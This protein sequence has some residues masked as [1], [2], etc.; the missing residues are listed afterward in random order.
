MNNTLSE[1][2]LQRSLHIRGVLS[3]L[4]MDASFEDLFRDETDNATQREQSSMMFT[5]SMYSVEECNRYFLKQD[6]V[7]DSR[8]V[9]FEKIRA[10]TSYKNVC[11][12]FEFILLLNSVSTRYS[13]FLNLLCLLY[14]QRQNKYIVTNNYIEEKIYR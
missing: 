7:H 2:S 6:C 3:W 12:H 14:R 1:F 4:L 10:K 5:I 9:C 11:S 13:K 8:H